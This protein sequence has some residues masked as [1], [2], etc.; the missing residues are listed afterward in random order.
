VGRAGR[1]HPLPCSL[2]SWVT[3][4]AQTILGCL[5]LDSVWAVI[6]GIFPPEPASRNGAAPGT[7]VGRDAVSGSWD[8]HDFWWRS[9]GRALGVKGGV[10]PE[11]PRGRH[12]GRA[13]LGQ[14]T[15][16]CQGRGFNLG[17]NVC[18]SIPDALQTPWPIPGG[19]GWVN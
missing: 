18:F 3:S 1:A 9:E 16:H 19:R 7:D 13:L 11:E 17:L 12:R 6:R 5:F 2:L 4:A 8:V 15:A 14:S 10:I